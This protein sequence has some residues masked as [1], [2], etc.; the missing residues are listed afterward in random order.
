MSEPD[1]TVRIW[2]EGPLHTAARRNDLAALERALG[3]AEGPGGDGEAAIDACDL[4]GFTA[5]HVAAC[6]A[7]L[8]LVKRLL[9]AGALVDARA[10]HDELTPLMLAVARGRVDVADALL[11]A[12]ADANA[13]TYR[14]RLYPMLSFAIR[15]ATLPLLERLAAAGFTPRPHEASA[16]FRL[17]LEALGHGVRFFGREY[18]QGADFDDVWVVDR[19]MTVPASLMAP[20]H[21]LVEPSQR[22]G[23]PS[24]LLAA[25]RFDPAYAASFR[26]DPDRYAV[27]KDRAPPSRIMPL[28][29]VAHEVRCGRFEVS[30]PYM[31]GQWSPLCFAVVT[32]QPAV[33]LALV[34]SAGLDPAAVAAE[35]DEVA[36]ARQ[37]E[38]GIYPIYRDPLRELLRQALAAGP[39]RGPRPP[40]AARPERD[41]PIQEPAR[42]RPSATDTEAFLDAIALCSVEDVRLFLQAGASP[43]IRDANGVPALL[44]VLSEGYPE[45]AL[46]LVEAGANV[47]AADRQGRTALDFAHERGDRELAA[48]LVKA[49]KMPVDALT[50]AR[51]I[52]AVAEGGEEVHVQASAKQALKQGKVFLEASLRGEDLS[53]HVPA[54]MRLVRERV[55]ESLSRALVLHFL[56]RGDVDGIRQLA[57]LQPAAGSDTV[58][59]GFHSLVQG[60]IDFADQSGAEIAAAYPLLAGRPIDGGWA[61]CRHLERHPER[62]EAVL[63]A[64]ASSPPEVLPE[65]V[66]RLACNISTWAPW[67]AA[68]SASISALVAKLLRSE[69]EA[70]RAAA[71]KALVA[72]AQF[73]ALDLASVAP[74]L[75]AALAEGRQQRPVGLALTRLAL[76]R[77]PADESAIER[78]L[79]HPLAEV[80]QAAVQVL[81][82]DWLRGRDEPAIVARL[83]AALLDASPAV[84]KLA[85]ETLLEGHGKRRPLGRLEAP[86]LALLVAA[87]EEPELADATAPFLATYA[88]SDP[89]RA[90][91]VLDALAAQPAT[92]A[93]LGELAAT[94]RDLLAAR[95]PE[96]CPLCRRLAERPR[97]GEDFQEPTVPPPPE[98]VQL[99]KLA[100]RPEEL[101]QCPHC[102]T[103]YQIKEGGGSFMNN[104]WTNYTLE[105][106]PPPAPAAVWAMT[107]ALVQKGD[108]QGLDRELLRGGEDRQR[109][110]LQVLAQRVEDGLDVAA[111][112]PTLRALLSEPESVATAAADVLARHWVRVGRWQDVLALSRR[113][114]PHLGLRAVRAVWSAAR[115]GWGDVGPFLSRA[116][117][118]LASADGGVR[119]SAR[120]ILDA[121]RGL[122]GE[123]GAMTVA[124]ATR[125]LDSEDPDIRSDAA[126]VLAEAAHQGADLTPA[127]PRIGARLR[128]DASPRWLLDALKHAAW[129]GADVSP[130]LPEL[131]A[132]LRKRKDVDEVVVVLHAIHDDGI[133]ISAALEAVRAVAT[134][135]SWAAALLKDAG[136]QA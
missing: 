93:R 42:Q 128:D 70:E 32:E 107:H 131:I 65:M 33:V 17:A 124:A 123:E 59:G 47:D 108:L 116:R 66:S 7:S 113:E 62:V 80:R 96:S 39:L 133:D 24:E 37:A 106:M 38:R 94:C 53:A 12:G 112:E 127:L 63:A 51:R 41:A 102:G 71:G 68:V 99:H 125:L 58:Y 110:A 29:E 49:S 89:A 9:A 6:E 129:D 73:P 43:D 79:T 31:A 72:C 67:P 76:S 4:L 56:R 117:E 27:E 114:E 18:G 44:V 84:R 13:S 85:A 1:A 5:L 40:V 50:R 121:G 126:F 86:L 111:L 61:L 22:A 55:R 60:A 90:R 46:L 2:A 15:G 11:A 23:A 82:W 48:A 92:S 103:C 35:S 100:P 64:V 54:L 122:H 19:P 109:E 91:D 104:D 115:Y 69:N 120:G 95:D 16:Y 28:H 34:E 136:E 21:A 36:E 97:W 88:M 30:K 98:L 75:A 10:E 20:L 26:S 25:T 135:G 130:L 14:A 52:I 77:E 74:E 45:L 87:V 105:R 132:R 57:E 78:L 119:G 8:D 134:P 118:L 3:A 101:Y 81:A 83:A